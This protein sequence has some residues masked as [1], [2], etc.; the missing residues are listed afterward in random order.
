[1]YPGYYSNQAPERPAVTVAESGERMSYGDLERRSRRL[2]RVFLQQGL[3]PGERLAL[4]LTNRVEF[5]VAAWA[6]LR[7]GLRVVPVNRYLSVSEVAYILD[8]SDARV[9]ISCQELQRVAVELPAVVPR[10]ERFFMIGTDCPGFES[11][12]AVIDSGG[13]AAL[14][15]EPL[16]EFM[17]YTSGSTGAPKGPL[18]PLSGRSA[19]DGYL[20]P[21]VAVMGFGGESRML[22]STPLYH[23]AS[24][25]F[26]MMPFTT[27]GSLVITERF[28]ALSVLRYIE[29]YRISHAYFV[30]TM[31]ARM[32]SLPERARRDFDSSSLRFVVH[33]A[34]PCPVE[35]KRRMI[36]WWGP[37]IFESY[38]ISE[39]HE[40]TWID[41][42]EW[43]T[44][45]SSVGRGVGCRIH[46]LDEFGRTVPAGTVGQVHIESPTAASVWYHKDPQKTA[47]AH[48]AAGWF[49]TGDM[50]YLDPAG[51]LHL[52]DRQHFMIISCGINIY[53]REV[54]N[55]L[56]GHGRVADAAVFGLPD[57]D[58]GERVVAVIAPRDAAD[59]TAALEQELSAYCLQRLARFKCPLQF[60]FLDELPRLPTGKI[61]K[62]RL[63]ER[64]GGAPAPLIS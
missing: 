38:G 7:V 37:V 54:E 10:V 34:E 2:A 20:D 36:E 48:T 29:R 39:C 24:L 28:D 12:D 23:S 57:P 6:G 60:F 13:D 15:S 43:L 49:A 42:H 35:I 59:A 63:R 55:V 58:L 32:L 17:C 18:W 3:Q 52:K 62:Q 21:G 27:G 53:P 31:F 16:G 40:H 26:A 51:Y 4:L 50:G 30:P 19:T 14:E 44:R 46:V 64:F 9:L 41:S 8:N 45:P 11:L 22:V 1:M 5:M 56:L 33:L 25:M 47:L 61:Y